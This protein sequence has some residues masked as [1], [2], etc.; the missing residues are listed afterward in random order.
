MHHPSSKGNEEARARYK[1]S[2]G[3]VHDKESDRPPAAYA[4][5]TARM[6]NYNDDTNNAYDFTHEQAKGLYCPK[7]SSAVRS[8][9]QLN[10]F[11]TETLFCRVPPPSMM[12]HNKI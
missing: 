2:N 8:P 12:Q 9:D 6:H 3:V 1:H 7:A 4:T 5:L 10:I 11:S